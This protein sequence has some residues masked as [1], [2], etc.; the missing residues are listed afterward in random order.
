MELEINTS[1]VGMRLGFA[2]TVPFIVEKLGVPPSKKVKSACYWTEA[3]YDL[4][5]VKLIA[6]L[7]QVQAEGYGEPPVKVPKAAKQEAEQATAATAAFVASEPAAAETSG[8]GAAPT[9]PEA[10]EQPA[11][12]GFGALIPAAAPETAPAQE[13]PTPDAAPDGF[14]NSFFA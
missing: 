7:Q 5:V 13:A 2:M 11:A 8:F 3:E 14:L 1:A 4:I 9:E 6:H 12:I 10:Q